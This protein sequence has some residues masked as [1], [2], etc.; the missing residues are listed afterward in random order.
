MEKA[1]LIVAGLLKVAKHLYYEGLMRDSRLY[2]F[3]IKGGSQWYCRVI[4]AGFV[5]DFW[6]GL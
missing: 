5:G 4:I 2:R 6:L 3:L 1:S